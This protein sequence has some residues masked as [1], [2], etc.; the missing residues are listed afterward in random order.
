MRLSSGFTSLLLACIAVVQVYAQGQ[1]GSNVFVLNGKIQGQLMDSIVLYY[2]DAYGKQTVLSQPLNKNGA[3]QFTGTLAGPTVSGLLMKSGSQQQLDE[4][5]SSMLFLEVGEITFDAEAGFFNRAKVVGSKTQLE[6][7][8]LQKL[9]E[10]IV[11]EMK[12]LKEAYKNEKDHE[13]AAEIREKFEPFNERIS[14]IEQDFFENHHGIVTA[15]QLRSYVSQLSFEKIKHFYDLLD[16]EV[17]Q[18]KYGKVLAQEI[19]KLQAGSPGSIATNFSTLDISGNP[20]SLSDFK[21]KYILLDFWASWC[22]PCRKSFPHLKE[23]YNKY[24]DKGLEVLCIGDNDS[25]PSDWKQAIEKD[26]IGMWYH[27]LRGFDMDKMR[28]GEKNENDISEK[29]GIHSLP[30]KI[31]VD[32]NGLIVGRY[33]G[34]GEDEDALDKK[35]E[36]LFG[37][38]VSGVAL[39]MGD[40]A[41]KLNVKWV[42]G[43][44]VEG[45]ENGKLYVIEF[46][47][48]WC[49][50]CKAAMPHLSELAHKYIGKITFVGVNV[51]EKGNHDKPYDSF[52]PSVKAFVDKMG[53]KMDY[54]VAMDNNDL[55]MVNSWMKAS[56]QQGIPASFIVKDR[57]IIWIGHPQNLDVILEEVVA[58]TYDMER[59]AKEIE[60]ENK[61]MNEMMATYSSLKKRVDDA[62]AAKNYASAISSID[63]VN[64]DD[65]QQLA[66]AVKSMKLVTYLKFNM[67]LALEFAN[68]WIAEDSDAK[69]VVSNIV[70]LEELLLPKGLYQIAVDYLNELLNDPKTFENTN[71]SKPMLY[72]FLAECYYRMNDK[73]N[74]IVFGAK[75]VEEG[76][77]DIEASR[78]G[79][80]NN[81]IKE[82]QDALV[83]YKTAKK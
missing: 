73:V 32:P 83:K 2:E 42:K 56:G 24:K 33:G 77:K 38:N 71:V 51:W 57:K 28:K 18:G 36:E 79:M 49:G 82:Y 76:K 75:T 40:Q 69:S 59:T 58:G 6:W 16:A 12:P 64:V 46:W 11:I 34:G 72:H 45:F 68:E 81:K 1:N 67:P 53:E 30:T 20:L 66:M 31:L 21:G 63:S 70:I 27:V 19:V 44:P 54:N 39:K 14:K 60:L 61:K 9:K 41:P 50:P 80:D 3:F 10:P 23:L 15:F 55:F 74:A 47:A 52:Y 78:P 17:K 7:D 35:L 22:V 65:N 5:N 13:K 25:R 62:V 37:G 48:T 4:A 29:F 26:G 8:Q 43:T